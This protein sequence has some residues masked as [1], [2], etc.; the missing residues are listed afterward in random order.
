RAMGMTVP[1]ARSML[2]HSAIHWPNTADPQWWPMAV[3]HA[4]YVHDA[5]QIALQYTNQQLTDKYLWGNGMDDLLA[6]ESVGGFNGSDITWTLNDH[7]GSVRDQVDGDGLLSHTDYDSFGNIESEVILD[8]SAADALFGY[9]ARPYDDDTDLQNNHNRWY[10][11][12][13]G[14]WISQDPIGFAA[15][16][17][18]LYRYV[19]NGVTTKVDPSGYTEKYPGVPIEGHGGTWIDGEPGHGTWKP[20]GMKV[21]VP[22]RKGRPN[23]SEFIYNKN[24]R[25]KRGVVTI[26]MTKS[27]DSPDSTR[28]NRDYTAADDAYRAKHKC[29]D[30]KRPT[31]WTWH[32]QS[33]HAN[34]K[35]QM[36]LI[37]EKIHS[38]SSHYG[39]YSLYRDILL[40]RRSGSRAQLR[41]LLERVKSFKNI[42][43]LAG[44]GGVIMFA[45]TAPPKVYAG[46]QQNGAA[47]AFRAGCREMVDADTVEDVVVF[48]AN[49]AAGLL[50]VEKSGEY[51]QMRQ[52]YKHGIKNDG[53]LGTPTI[54]G[55]YRTVD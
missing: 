43:V 32:H 8:A 38:A 42:R 44:L 11:S 41:T 20:D 48:P 25:N 9:T 37:P 51:R 2:L 34:G 46:Y 5:G 53:L 3:Q 29:P 30:W 4:A 45:F 16:D 1:M 49:Q 7:L 24:V 27:L 54:F 31:G 23:F 47:G 40:A 10:D 22:Y 35:A 15:G 28:R 26:R 17:A 6:H 33:L 39:P 52:P 13:T 55:G 12:T 50:M 36:I 14:R 18:N 19:G 21:K